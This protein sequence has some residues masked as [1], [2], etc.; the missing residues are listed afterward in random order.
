MSVQDDK[1]NLSFKVSGEELLFQVENY[2]SIRG[3]VSA[4]QNRLC[5]WRR[6]GYS[7]VFSRHC[8]AG[9]G[10]GSLV[11]SHPAAVGARPLLPM[12][13]VVEDLQFATLLPSPPSSCRCGW[14]PAIGSRSRRATLYCRT[15]DSAA[16]VEKSDGAGQS[17]TVEETCPWRLK[18]LV[19]GGSCENGLTGDRR[20]DFRNIP[21]H[22]SPLRSRHVRRY[23]TQMLVNQRLPGKASAQVLS[24]RLE[25]ASGRY[26][27]S[28][29]V[30]KTCVRRFLRK[31][32]CRRL[33][34]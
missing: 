4:G 21:A 7:R 28:G 33:Q 2:S 1:K 29:A 20:G 30:E 23:M 18:K 12:M 25:R 19:R 6:S 10:R 5:R 16:A 17:V 9:L 15:A 27:Q 34:R 22:K 14:S 11:R 26:G 8:T 32:A 31:R 24:L 3:L 13:F